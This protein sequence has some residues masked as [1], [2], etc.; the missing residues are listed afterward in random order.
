MLDNDETMAEEAGESPIEQTNE[1]ASWL[2][3]QTVAQT[4]SFTP[5][6]QSSHD[7]ATNASSYFSQLSGACGCDTH[8]MAQAGAYEGVDRAAA[9]AH[10]PGSWS[11]RPAAWTS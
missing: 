7:Q 2:G 1:A 11:L 3:R 10:P 4:R 9:N 8:G 5:G 6:G